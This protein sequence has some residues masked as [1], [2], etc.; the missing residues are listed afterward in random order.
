MEELWRIHDS[1]L[2][3]W[4]WPQNHV[5][6]DGFARFGPTSDEVRGGTH[7]V[8]GKLVL[9]LNILLKGSWSSDT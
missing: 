4:F 9:G 8:I 3:W 6:M 7:G 2:V 1:S 5:L